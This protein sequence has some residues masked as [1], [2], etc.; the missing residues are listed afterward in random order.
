MAKKS[1]KN[2]VVKAEPL[3]VTDD[4][5]T[6]IR[7]ASKKAKKTLVVKKTA[8]VVAPKKDERKEPSKMDLATEFLEEHEGLTRADAIK[9]FMEKCGLS[10]AGAGTYFQLLKTKLNYKVAKREKKEKTT[11]KK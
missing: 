8:P 2:P 10:K 5:H 9:A 6:P 1:T 7:P 4:G 11:Q 3:P